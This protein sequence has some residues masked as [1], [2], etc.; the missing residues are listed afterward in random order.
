MRRLLLLA[1]LPGLLAACAD[2]AAPD[3]SGRVL[4]PGDYAWPARND[5]AG[6]FVT[7]GG[8]S[9]LLRID[10][11]PGPS[12]SAL[13][14]H[15]GTAP[16]AD[17]MTISAAGDTLR[18]TGLTAA[19]LFRLPSAM[20]LIRR[21]PA[22]QSTLLDLAGWAGA[23][24]LAAVKGAG[25]M[26]CELPSGTWSAT[27]APAMPGIIGLHSIR[28]D[29]TGSYAACAFDSNGR[30]IMTLD[31]GRSWRS[32]QL[33]LQ[34]PTDVVIDG[35][36]ALACT[37]DGMIFLW[38]T[39]DTTWRT[40]AL[41]SPVTC[42]TFNPLG[43]GYSMLW[44]GGS[45]GE[46]AMI[47]VIPGTPPSL[48]MMNGFQSLAVTQLSTIPNASYS[49][50]AV[51]A[52]STL[53]TS[54]GKTWTPLKSFTTMV[55]DVWL[56]PNDGHIAIATDGGVTELPVQN[57]PVISLKGTALHSMV[58][59][60][61]GTLVCAGE[62]VLFHAARGTGNWTEI[63][64]PGAGT[65]DTPSELRLLVPH[66]RLGSTWSCGD[67]VTGTG[68]NTSVSRIITARVQLVLETLVSSDRRQSW[69]D[70]LVV[71]YAVENAA[72][73]PDSDALHVVAWYARGIG[74]VL[75]EHH[76]PGG[77]T[78]RTERRATDGQ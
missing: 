25:V 27:T 50:L 61:T 55:R 58:E 10:I 36:G 72:G 30:V 40:V 9:T 15:V 1:I 34:H 11:L 22:A 52:N 48:T 7:T 77:R 26:K 76:E 78:I 4:Q 70:I 46:V 44:V 66:M 31:N 54:L 45:Q 17:T 12:V 14:H 68:T 60:Q 29:S 67:L 51:T 32:I 73:E 37:A 16:T 35:Q 56:S 64:L 47:E 75:I 18:A 23:S 24:V 53:W 6:Y 38:T 21:T 49:L 59:T 39:D 20:R 41:G 62:H 42:L 74:P 3:G 8:D 43:R 13:V 69:S 63:P 65:I 19:T 28:P 33:P 5:S 71:R 57:D 2:P